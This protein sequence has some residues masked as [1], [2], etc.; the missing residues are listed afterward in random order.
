MRESTR[1]LILDAEGAQLRDMASG[2]QRPV[3]TG[4]LIEE[5]TGGEA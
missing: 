2:E 4:N 1:L 5:I 3:E